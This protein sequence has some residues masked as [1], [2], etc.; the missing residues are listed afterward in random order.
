MTTHRG[1]KPTG[2]DVTLLL[3]KH[4]AAAPPKQSLG[5]KMKVMGK[6]LGLVKV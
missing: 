5:E 6:M 1:N 4:N 3:L 2:D